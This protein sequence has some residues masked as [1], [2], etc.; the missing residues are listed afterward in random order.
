[1]TLSMPW[2]F[3]TSRLVIR[4]WDVADAPALKNAIDGNLTWLQAW[5]PWA[6]AEPSPLATIVSRL[7]TFRSDFAAGVEWPSAI[8]NQD[9]SRLLGGIGLHRTAASCVLELGYWVQASESGRGYVTEAVE[10]WTTLALALPG[11][12]RV[13]IHCDPRNAA[14]IAVARRAGFHHR[15]TML[16]EAVT[17]TGEPRDTMVWERNADVQTITTPR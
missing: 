12:T 14:S 8:L 3:E 5:M 1:M 7:E 15:E 9:E 13:V 11:I 16:A 6:M 2:R 10:A 4:A 17:P